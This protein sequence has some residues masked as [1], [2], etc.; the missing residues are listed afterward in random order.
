MGFS[1][2]ILSNNWKTMVRIKKMAISN[3]PS[4]NWKSERKRWKIKWVDETRNH[5]VIDLRFY[6][7]LRNTC[8]K[9]RASIDWKWKIYSND[10]S[11]T[12]NR[13]LSMVVSLVSTIMVQ[14]VVQSKRICCRNGVGI[15]FWKN[16]CSKSI[17]RSWRRKTFSSR[18][19]ER[20]A[21][22]SMTNF[23]PFRASGH[24]DRFA[25]FMVKDVKTGECFRA[26]H[27]IEGKRKRHLWSTCIQIDSRLLLQLISRN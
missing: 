24:V 4:V 17:V 21:L 23:P 6:S 12:I 9:R 13:S 5:I 2:V 18:S 11:S 3:K 27:L 1:R 19:S 15:S 14:W 8:P 10:D 16:R 25:D 26:D 20:W 7:R 22:P